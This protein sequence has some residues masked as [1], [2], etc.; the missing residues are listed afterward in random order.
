MKILFVGKTDFTYN[1]D[2]ILLAGLEVRDDVE[3][4]K[5]TIKKRDWKT[6]N[7]IKDDS[8]EVDFVFVPSFRHRDLA[9]VKRYSKAP[10]IFDPLISKYL[11][12]I[13]DYGV[14]WKAP[15]KY[16]VDWLAFHRANI[17]IW[18]T[19]QHHD[20]LKKMY[21]LHQ[22]STHIYIGVDTN[23]FYPI[24][25]IKENNEQTVVGFY[26]SFNPLQGID[27][28]VK[29]ANLLRSHT[30]IRFE[31]IGF[32]AT[33]IEIM[34]L[35]SELQ[36]TNITW[37][38]KVPYEELNAAINRFDICLGVFGKSKKA[39]LVIPNK[40]FHYTGA[41]KATITRKTDGILEIFNHDGREEIVTVDGTPE[42]LAE[43][44]LN[45]SNDREKRESVAKAGYDLVSQNYNQ[46][47]IAASFVNF[48]EPYHQDG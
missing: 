31:I 6:G 18:D 36:I 39:D 12:K 3:V 15:Y 32:G 23:K 27:V 46:H 44:I 11:T 13:G 4:R 28:I 5:L 48:L 30:N 20:Y 42:E 29:A 38:P 16:V 45:L 47:K 25:K 9:F 40:I 7:T 1:R 41:Q 2:A 21:K 19:K 22:S 17:L 26:G 8:N 14:K 35:S 33:Y 34:K 43:A 10:V 37:T 24:E